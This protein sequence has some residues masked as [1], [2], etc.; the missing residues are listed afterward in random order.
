[1][2]IFWYIML[3]G[4]VEEVVKIFAEY[5]KSHGVSIFSAKETDNFSAEFRCRLFSAYIGD[6]ETCEDDYGWIADEFRTK[7]NFDIYVQLYPD[8]EVRIFAGL[9]KFFCER[10]D[11]DIH[12]EDEWDHT[13]LDRRNGVL[14]IYDAE[15]KNWFV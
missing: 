10:Y 5:V 7:V 15:W 14:E 13:Y 1:M 3:K 4:S 11:G 8:C 12:L 6:K 9:V 2:Q